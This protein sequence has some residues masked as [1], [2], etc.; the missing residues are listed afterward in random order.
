MR[1]EIQ[2]LRAVAVLGVL[3]FH[4]WPGRLPGGYVGVDVFFVVSG[5]LITDHLIRE[6]LSR[7]RIRLPLFWARRARRLLPASLTV[8][9]ATALGVWLFVPDARWSQFGSEIV[10]SVLYTENWALAAQSVD[11]MALSNAKSPV[12]H[13][14]SLGVEEQFYLVWPLLILAAFAIATVARRRPVGTVFA[15]IGVAS[16]A[17]LAYSIWSTT[18]DPS[19]AYFSTFARAWEFGAGG[20]LALLLRRFGTPLGTGL[21]ASLASW[22]GLVGIAAAMLL[23]TGAT[24]FPSYTALL[25][26]GGTML[27]IAAGTP[28][29]ALAPTRLFRLR[30][31]QFLGDV[32][33]GTY[34]WH[35]PIIV[36]LPYVLGAPLST[37]WAVAALAV[38]IL[39]GWA[40]KTFIED[41]IRTRPLVVRT[42]PR[43][44][45][46]ST[47][48]AMAAVAAVALPLATHRIEAPTAMPVAEQPDCY[49][50]AAMLDSACAPAEEIPLAA[51]LSS[52]AVD[53]PPDDILACE[54]AAT[55]GDFVRC[56][57]GDLTG[58]GPHIALVG[59]SHATRLAEPL[60]DVAIQR[61]GSLSTFLVSGCAMM[62]SEVTGSAWGYDAT[63]SQQCRDVTDRIQQ[64]VA[65]DA[66]IQTVVMTDRTRLYVT[67][68]E[69]FHPLTT[70]MVQRSI[71][72]LQDAGK[73]VVVI[74]DPPEMHAVPP[75]GGGSAVDCL[76]SAQPT[77]CSLP[78]AESEFDDPLSNAATSVGAGLIDLDDAFC[79]HDRCLSRIGGL[80]VYSDDNHLTR[81]FALSLVGVLDERLSPWLDGS[82]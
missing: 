68:D 58:D 76:S 32:S 44:T 25:P 70:D 60:R 46:A 6:R 2:A 78:R 74:T 57:F 47:L 69:G 19:V 77:Q 5:F 1:R 30:P 42:K 56:D 71:V 35:W 29:G 3:L 4:L 12:Q 53:V 16:A 79:T 41:P 37:A 27:M 63:A 82:R 39:L 75:Q 52:F 55:S 80:V 23:Y 33:Y 40:S 49:G 20:L 48:V 54:Q 8:L 62:S 21:S 61:G 36:I 18:V 38:S 11:Y 17:S 59:D 64:A 81:S 24:P 66:G 72:R 65:E 7:G 51:S 14:W 28:T 67:D 34:L 13:F 45:F 50:A 15:V 31:V 26:V 10:A 73:D 22:T 43:W 9:A